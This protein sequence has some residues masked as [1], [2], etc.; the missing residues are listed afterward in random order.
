MFYKFI[1]FIARIIVKLIFFVKYNNKKV[2]A[3][4]CIES[5]Y[6]IAANHISLFDP[7]FIACAA[8]RNVHYM[9]KAEAFRKKFPAWFLKKVCAF[10]VDRSK[11]DI[12]AVK[13]SLSLLKNGDILG[14][15]PE[16]RR[17]APNESQD[18]KLGAVQFAFKTNCPIIPVGV[19]SKGGTVRPFKKVTI[20]FGE[21]VYLDKIGIT[22]SKPESMH[23]ASDHIM[24]QIRKLADN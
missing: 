10:P 13:T 8:K 4:D 12:N 1:R 18:A 14:I 3:E 22:D 17:V 16:G 7:V 6:I 21:P 2:V 19:H 24:E 23:R 20:T 15:F 5:G 11:A 9:A